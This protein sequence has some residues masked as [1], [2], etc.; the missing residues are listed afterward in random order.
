MCEWIVNHILFISVSYWY[1]WRNAW[2]NSKENVHF[3][4][5]VE[6]QTTWEYVWSVSIL[7]WQLTKSKQILAVEPMTLNRTLRVFASHCPLSSYRSSFR[8]GLVTG[9]KPVIHPILH[10]LLQRIT[11]LNKRAYLARFLV[12]LEVPAEF[13]QGGVITD[14]CHQ[15]SLTLTS[16]CKHNMG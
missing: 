3:A 6:I 5:D 15:V 1:P 14:T 2:P 11:E 10:W 4:R 13:L 8:Q 16:R 12:K 9:S 7:D